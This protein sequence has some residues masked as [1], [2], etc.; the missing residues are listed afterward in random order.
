MRLSQSPQ[1]P[2]PE[3]MTTRSVGCRGL[4]AFC[5]ARR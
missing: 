4:G 5:F 1:R 2:A 3:P